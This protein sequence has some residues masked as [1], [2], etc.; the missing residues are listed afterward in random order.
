MY[1]FYVGLKCR[2]IG[3]LA[4]GDEPSGRAVFPRFLRDTAG[5]REA[6]CN[7]FNACVRVF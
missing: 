6:K 7:F 3:G 5:E 4:S 2:A 1:G